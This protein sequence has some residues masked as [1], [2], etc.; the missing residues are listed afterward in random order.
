MKLASTVSWSAL[1]T[2]IRL[3]NGGFVSMKIVAVLVGPIGVA[4]IGQFG[5]FNSIVMV[6]ALG[7]VSS[8]VI[9]TLR[10]IK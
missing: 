4:L 10:N 3:A 7:G 5:N 9:S 2:I 6:L 1:A 8:G